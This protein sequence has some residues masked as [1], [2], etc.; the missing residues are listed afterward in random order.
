M[1]SMDD[2][3]THPSTLSR[4][5]LVAGAAWGVP[6]VM[7]VGAAPAMAA[8]RHAQ[9]VA[10][11]GTATSNTGSWAGVANVTSN[12]PADSAAT[13][14][15]LNQH[16]GEAWTFTATGFGFNLPLGAVNISVLIEVRYRT[17]TSDTAAGTLTVTASGPAGTISTP[18]TANT[19]STATETSTSYS[20][21][22][23]N[24]I[25]FTVEAYHASRGNIPDITFSV[26]FIRVTVDYDY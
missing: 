14:T 23:V 5:T 19:W 20:I 15:M 8:S 6:A 17:S 24:A 1:V 21:S 9:L 16:K 2:M 3:D 11:P 7:V 18:L 22:Q 25:N 26:D 4:R 13:A 10:F 12:T